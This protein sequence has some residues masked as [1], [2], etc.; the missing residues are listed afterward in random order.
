MKKIYLVIVVVVAVIGYFVYTSILKP[1][2]DNR[3]VT[4]VV[5]MTIKS[6][7]TSLEFTY[8]SGED[9][10]SLIEP[11]VPEGLSDGLRKVY[12]LMDTHDYIEF[13]KDKNGDTPPT[14]SVFVLD[15]PN[16]LYG[17]NGLTEDSKRIDKLKAWAQ[18][19]TKYS[20]Y[21]QKTAEPEEVKLDG[22][23]TLHY[24][25]KGDYQQDVYVVMYNGKVYVFNGQFTKDKEN[26][27]KMFKELIGSVVFD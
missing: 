16:S 6:S 24:L 22:A 23:L 5:P 12:I 10:Y 25:T 20:S 27:H 26:I 11:P 17:L 14:V 21:N 15:F 8:P 7:D 1:Q 4:A 3:T 13:Q 18:K 19:Y 2:L 9:G